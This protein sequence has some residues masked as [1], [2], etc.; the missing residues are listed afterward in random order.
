MARML[1]SL[2]RCSVMK[3]KVYRQGEKIEPVWHM[4]R[5]NI[6]GSKLVVGDM[7]AQIAAC[8]IGAQRYLELIDRWGLQTVTDAYA[9]LLDYSERLMRKAIGELPDGEY[10]ATTILDGY[11]DEAEDSKKNLPICVNIKVAG[12][13]LVV[14][15]TGTAPQV[16]DK[17][18]NMPLQGTVDIA[19][20]LTLRSVLLDS[21]VYG[22]I[23]QN[24]GLIRPIELQVPKGTITNPIFP[25]PTIARFCPG[26]Q[27]A[28][29]V[30]YFVLG[31]S[32]SNPLGA[33]GDL[34]R[35]IRWSRRCRRHGCD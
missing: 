9:D 34:R 1:R 2:C 16:D 6:R 27:L 13:E 10:S 30:S 19:I 33:Y 23:P 31:Y 28:D 25:A 15:L 35:C 29:T 8:H 7:E 14:D 5:D 3:S 32:G 21:D 20:W 26:N 12:D 22:Y 17:P 24:S 18:I 11:L 4:L